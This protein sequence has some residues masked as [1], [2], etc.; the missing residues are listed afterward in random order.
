MMQTVAARLLLGLLTAA[1]AA[2]P[3]AAK[4][5]V[6]RDQSVDFTALRTYVFKPAARDRTESRIADRE[7]LEKEVRRLIEEHLEAEGFE[8]AGDG[9]DADFSVAVDGAVGDDFDSILMRREIASGISWVGFGPAESVE[10]PFREGQRGTL[11][12]TIRGADGEDTL[13]SGW[14]SEIVKNPD[15]PIPQASRMIRKI[16][17]RFPPK[18]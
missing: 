10:S 3:V 9:E 1:L 14:T 18:R 4:V 7:A 13:W 12:V 5:H 8:P 11:M 15:R 2:Q 16:L 6:K 17:K